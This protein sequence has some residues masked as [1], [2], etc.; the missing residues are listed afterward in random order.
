MPSPYDN[1]P[2]DYKKKAM[3]EENKKNANEFSYDDISLV[4]EQKITG[5]EKKQRRIFKKRRAGVV[6]SEDEVKAIKQGRKKLR[7]EMKARGIK[8][9]REFELVAGSLGL[10][11][12]KRRG[13]FF[14][15]WRHWLG[16]LLGLL[17]AMLLI[18][19][20]FSLVQ[21]MRGHFTINLSDGMFKE[22]FVLADNKEFDNATT[23]LFSTP[24]QDVPCIS[25]NQI[26]TDID[27]IDG[28]HNEQYFAYTYYIRN[29]GESTVGYDWTLDFNEETKDLSKAAWIIVFEDGEMRIF[30]EANTSSGE[31][32][33]LP[34][35]DD[36]SRGY[37]SLPI[38]ELAPDSD[39]FEIVKQ[40]GQVT[41]WRV[42]P[43]K[44]LSEDLI[45]KGSQ[46]GVE[47]KEVH[48]YTVVIYLEGDDIEADDSRIGGHL[49]LEMNFK[50]TSEAEEKKSIWDGLKFW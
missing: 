36:D 12:D 50:L 18:L 24:A 7:K 35:L 31:A 11:F 27:E 37:S 4:G 47:P 28:E 26:P 14:W 43:D 32:E 46:E 10:Y 17:A 45:T 21:Q 30:A 6:L 38:R 8:S 16:A 20:I 39:Q 22:G 3:V 19:F 48:K 44:F 23:Q 33:A 29:E 13:F 9:K 49:G 25:I 1:L 15:L 40:V 42:I 34:P 2:D 41:Y 5:E